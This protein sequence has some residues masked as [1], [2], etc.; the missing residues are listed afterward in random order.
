MSLVWQID[1]KGG[2]LTSPELSTEVRSQSQ[3]MQVFRNFVTL[4]DSEANFGIH[5]G[6]T[7]Q[8]V[9][10]S[11]TQ[12]GRVVGE[13]E[14]VPTGS[15]NFFRDQVV[16][17]EFTLGIDYSWRLDTLAKLDVHHTLVQALINSMTRTLDRAC[18]AIY[19][20]MD[21]V[22]TPIGSRANPQ[23]VLGTAGVPLAVATRP[24]S[25]YDHMNII[26]LMGGTYHMP[27][28][29]TNNYVS[30][31]TPKYC[32][33]FFEDSK[34]ERIVTPNNADKFYSAEIGEIYQ[35][36][37]TKETN[38]LDNDLGNDLGEAVYFG[39]DAVMEMVVHPEEIQAKLGADYGRDRGLRW[40]WFGNW[41]QTW[42]F[43][44]EGE[45]R[46][47]RVYSL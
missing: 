31:G 20:A 22:Y 33:S 35:G 40:V 32:R 38:A 14:L 26:D 43:P 28:Y 9:K 16:A 45:A 17:Q 46:G 11:D 6:D 10:V 19:R 42:S 18:A 41:V 30:V 29:D 25:L 34:F 39:K 23:F 2:F 36:R 47:I 1:S 4:A 27:L 24:F 37:I 13:T 21:L 7:M 44:N 5:R 3:T 12:D 8:F 15:L